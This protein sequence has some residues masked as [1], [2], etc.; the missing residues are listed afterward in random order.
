MTQG[1]GSK[2]SFI[3]LDNGRQFTVQ[4]NPA[5]FSVT[6][7]L[8]WE[9]TKNQ[10]LDVNSVQFQKGAPMTATFDLY[11]DTTGDG[12]DVKSS[13]TDGLLSL[14][15]ADVTPAQGEPSE[16]G[17][18]RP[19]S[20]QFVW[21]SFEMDCVIESISVTFL[22]FGADGTP[23]RAKAAVKLKEWKPPD[24]GDSSGG[25]SWD[26]DKLQLVEVQGG[27]TLSQVASQNNSDW[28]QLALDNGITDPLADLTGDTLVFRT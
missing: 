6:K 24:F 1:G 18:M 12:S 7:A 13:W 22:M 4:Y 16:L 14:T 25:F 8:T 2:A 26:S 9:E 10:G 20:F 19:A 23:I 28:R 5:Q 11:F 3:S 21:G 27:Q 17:K 15:K